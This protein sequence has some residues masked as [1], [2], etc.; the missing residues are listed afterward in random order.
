MTKIFANFVIYLKLITRNWES[1]DGPGWT[2]SSGRTITH[3]VHLWVIL[4]CPGNPDKEICDF[5][6]EV[7]HDS[8]MEQQFMRNHRNLYATAFEG[9]ED[10]QIKAGLSGQFLSRGGYFVQVSVE[11][12]K[13]N[14]LTF[15][16]QIMKCLIT[17]NHQCDINQN[18]HI[19]SNKY[20]LLSSRLL[21]VGVRPPWTKTAVWGPSTRPSHERI[22]TTDP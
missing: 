16:K 7:E 8:N 14:S 19:N 2:R 3:R 6:I 13:S 21:S 17:E 18:Y 1:L 15:I 12:R 20:I 10:Y 5:L 22:Q 4:A 9:I 11:P